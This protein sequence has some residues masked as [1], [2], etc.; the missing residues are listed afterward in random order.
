MQPIIMFEINTDNEVTVQFGRRPSLSL[1]THFG[2]WP[3]GFARS[4]EV[5]AITR[6]FICLSDCE[7]LSFFTF[8]SKLSKNLSTKGDLHERLLTTIH[9]FL[10]SESSWPLSSLDIRSYTRTLLHFSLSFS[11]YATFLKAD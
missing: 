5:A 1:K 6:L 11:W 3:L 7:D 9:S 10:S 8:S 4:E 2:K